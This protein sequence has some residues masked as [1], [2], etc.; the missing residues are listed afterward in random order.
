MSTAQTH[1]QARTHAET[2][3][4]DLGMETYDPARALDFN[5]RDRRHLAP[6]DRWLR[7]I[8]TSSID[9]APRSNCRVASLNWICGKL[10]RRNVSWVSSFSVD[11]LT[12]VQIATVR[13][14]VAHVFCKHGLR[15]NLRPLDVLLRITVQILRLWPEVL[16]YHPAQLP[17]QRFQ[18]LFSASANDH[19]YQPGLAIKAWELLRD[20]LYVL[21]TSRARQGQRLLILIDRLD[22]CKSN[23][24]QENDVDG[25]EA[26]TDFAVVGDLVYRLAELTR[27]SLFLSLLVTAARIRGRSIKGHLALLGHGDVDVSEPQL[28]RS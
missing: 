27:G 9:L 12:A 15:W 7:H 5:D 24:Y 26:V 16:M 3:I 28:V 22:L 25:T 10:A 8:K 13:N 18:V 17:R 14:N 4:K 19:A 6:A 23:V 21:E 1:F 20:M 2:M 11:L